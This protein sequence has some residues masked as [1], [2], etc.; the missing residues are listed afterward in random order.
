VIK[1]FAFAAI[2]TDAAKKARALPVPDHVVDHFSQRNNIE[3][4]VVVSVRASVVDVRFDQH[5]PPIRRCC[6]LEMAGESSSKYW[7]TEMGATFEALR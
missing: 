2:F 1:L 7:R 4:D 3:P 6:A 5:L